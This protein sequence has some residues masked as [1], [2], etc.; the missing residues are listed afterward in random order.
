VGLTRLEALAL[1]MLA[2]G[3]VA[4]AMMITTVGD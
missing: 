4:I 3:V 1:L 2:L